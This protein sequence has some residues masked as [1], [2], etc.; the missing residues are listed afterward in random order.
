MVIVFLKTFH[1]KTLILF[2][3]F[4]RLNR[5]MGRICNSVMFTYFYH[6]SPKTFNYSPRCTAKDQVL[7][8]KDADTA[9][10]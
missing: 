7:I 3:L 4:K 5:L 1:P 2:Q 10:Y 8:F 6:A 9:R